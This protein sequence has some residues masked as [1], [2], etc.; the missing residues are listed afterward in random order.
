[1]EAMLE[2]MSSAEVTQWMAYFKVKAFQAEQDMKVRR[3]EN[4][5]RGR[6]R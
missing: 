1:M 3:M 4:D 2:K 6:R 5:M